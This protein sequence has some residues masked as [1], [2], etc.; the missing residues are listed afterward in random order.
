VATGGSSVSQTKRDRSI[1]AQLLKGHRQVEVGFAGHGNTCEGNGSVVS[2]G[3]CDDSRGV[4]RVWQLCPGAGQVGL[5]AAASTQAG[6]LLGEDD[7]AVACSLS[8]AGDVEQNTCQHR[9]TV[10]GRGAVR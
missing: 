1:G 6:A 7:V 2:H 8:Q 5:Q 4:K 10:C 9:S 3:E